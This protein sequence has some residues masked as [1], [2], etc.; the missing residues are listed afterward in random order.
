MGIRERLGRAL[1]G[2]DE[3]DKLQGAM[4]LMSEA[5]RRGPYTL[6]PESLARQLG[7][8]DSQLVDLLLRQR[9]YDLIAGRGYLGQLEFSEADRL[10]VVDQ[11]RWAYHFDVQA[12]R[13]VNAWTD[14]GLGK[15]VVVRPQD[16]ALAEVWDEFWTAK[17]NRNLLKES[18][19]DDNSTMVVH[20]GELFFIFYAARAGGQTTIRRLQTNNISR[21]VYE[22]D[23]GGNEDSDVPL[24]YV[25]S[26]IG[27]EIW[28]PDW[29]ASD[30]QL[31]A[32]ELPTGVQRADQMREQTDVR[33]QRVS[34][35]DIEG[36]GW[37]II[38]RAIAWYQGYKESLWDWAAVA[39]AVAMYPRKIKH[40]GGSRA[41]DAIQ[42]SIQSSLATT[43]YGYDRNPPA[44]AGS[45]WIE[46]Q[47]LAAE[48]DNPM[49]TGA[50]EWQ[51]GTGLLAGQMSAGDGL[52]LVY[53]GRPD[54]N[55]NRSVAEVSTIP[56]D[57]QMSRYST[58]WHDTYREWVEIV[59]TFAQR[60]GA[61]VRRFETFEADVS[62]S[63]PATLATRT[64]DLVRSFSA[65][66]A[67]A[68]NMTVDAQ[69]ARAA[70]SSLMRLLLERFGLSVVA[71]D[72]AASTTEP[73]TVEDV[74][75][76][77]YQNYRDGTIG[78]DA[79][80]EYLF[81]TVMDNGGQE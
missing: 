10:N 32:V 22:A 23:E 74:T 41:T 35:E 38:R 27:G 77:A 17:R 48:Y 72:D 6:T 59:G 78:V 29:S 1:L 16:E 57:L 19:L 14:F 5:Y 43:G 81:A 52:P 37:P 12:G 8:M 60:Y 42:T 80:A 33:A 51:Q 30:A 11:A 2:R 46:N 54:T 55:Q 58:M 34:Y 36:R 9:G 7:E 28:Y 69:D 56:F 40:K 61:P 45:T 62:A 66:D 75:M 4:E 3:M 79:L 13:A 26:T 70:L 24:F 53:R 73:G 15:E 44:V 39:S 21:I 49:R 50:M 31:N 64:D 20:D 71:D 63:R 18:R 76:Q 67:A 68:V 25:Q 65:I 47:A